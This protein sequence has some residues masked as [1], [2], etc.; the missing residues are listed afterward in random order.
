[1][2]LFDKTDGELE[3]Y[4]KIKVVKPEGR[5]FEVTL[6]EEQMNLL[7]LLLGASSPVKRGELLG[8]QY[9]YDIGPNL[10]AAFSKAFHAV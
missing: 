6:D 3:M 9:D 1:V 10:H 4:P 5:I 8:K 2:P 7:T